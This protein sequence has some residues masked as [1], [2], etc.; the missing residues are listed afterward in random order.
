MLAYRLIQNRV[1]AIPT[2]GMF[3]NY[4]T[5]AFRNLGRSKIYSFINIF[6]LSL[7]LACAMLII[8]YV[9][10]EVS[11]DGF[12]KNGNNIYRIVSKNSYKGEERKSGNTGFLQ[13]P[14]F[15]ANVPGIE[16][17]VRIQSGRRDIKKGA[18]IQS[19]DLLLVDSAFFTVFSFPLLYGNPESC[20]M[21]PESIV[22]SEDEAIKQFGSR[23][24]VGKTVMLKVDS[25]FSPLRV[26]A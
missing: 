24:A 15:A 14:R 23:D 20:L 10:D 11:Y 22:L 26:S 13:G 9:K 7:G 3:K 19:H 1:S 12:H 21:D 18:D 16:S 4:F 5:T 8:L 2:T 25:V 17:F 6:G